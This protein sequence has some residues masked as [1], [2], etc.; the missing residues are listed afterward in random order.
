M[1]VLVPAL[2]QSL[3][4]PVSVW[5]GQCGVHEGACPLH[6]HS[7]CTRCTDEREAVTTLAR[8]MQ[9]AQQ[10]NTIVTDFILAGVGFRMRGR[11]RDEG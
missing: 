9:E 11:M 3:Q 8:D 7:A 1:H 5:H 4:Y 10:N 6:T 2:L